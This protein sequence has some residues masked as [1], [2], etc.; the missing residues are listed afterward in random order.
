[1][2]CPAVRGSV[3]VNPANTVIVIGKQTPAVCNH[4]DRQPAETPGIQTANAYGN[5][6]GHT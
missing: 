6:A 4:P 2:A 3:H 5:H 1:M